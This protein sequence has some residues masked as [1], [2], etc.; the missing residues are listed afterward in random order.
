MEDSEIRTHKGA[1]FLAFS[2]FL[3][4]KF[5]NSIFTSAGKNAAKE[6]AVLKQSRVHAHA[7]AP[8]HARTPPPPPPTHAQTPSRA[9]HPAV[10]PGGACAAAPLLRCV[11]N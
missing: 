6:N 9:P 2:P 11:W 3:F 8:A 7:P 5:R 10:L 4:W 1:K